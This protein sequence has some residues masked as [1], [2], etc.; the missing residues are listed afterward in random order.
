M[1]IRNCIKSFLVL[2]LLKFTSINAMLNISIENKMSRDLFITSFNTSGSVVRNSSELID[3]CLKNNGKSVTLRINLL[4]PTCSAESNSVE[5]DILNKTKTEEEEYKAVF[6]EWG[7]NIIKVKDNRY[8][9]DGIYRI[10]QH[11]DSLGGIIFTF[12][13]DTP[14]VVSKLRSWFTSRLKSDSNSRQCQDKV[15]IEK[16]SGLTPNDFVE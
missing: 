8:V 16:Y 12:Y 5:L 4:S 7:K 13:D 2:L 9:V 6:I 10:T 1:K 15:L 3:S 11:S 14:L